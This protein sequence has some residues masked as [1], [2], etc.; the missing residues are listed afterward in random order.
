MEKI[1]LPFFYNFGHQLNILTQFENGVE[2]RLEIFLSANK[3]EDGLLFLLGPSLKLVYC[4]TSGLD[5]Y[6]AIKELQKWLKETE[7]PNWNAPDEKVTTK[8]RKVV[9]K[10]KEF[11]TLLCAELQTLSVYHVTQIGIYSTSD[12]I[13]YAEKVF[14]PSICSK[15]DSKVIEEVRQSGRCLAFDCNT[16]SAFHIIRALELV[17]HDYYI[18]ICKPKPKTRLPNWGAYISALEK[19]Q[20]NPKVKE[21]IAIIQQIKDQHRNLIMHP[22]LV[23]TSDDAFTQFDIAKAAIATMIEQIPNK[24]KKREVPPVI[25]AFP[26]P[27]IPPVL[28]PIPPIIQ[29]RSINLNNTIINNDR[30]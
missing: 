26:Y 11:E 2:Q 14:P 12:L 9:S 24:K 25:R 20:N 22:E 28:K 23:L 29:P 7:P 6:R 21:V 27:I 30:Q 18:F 1:N 17:L 15:L 13:T 10:A 16:A 4:R 5:L 19:V 8:F 3:V